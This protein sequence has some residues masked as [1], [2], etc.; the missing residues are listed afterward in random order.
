MIYAFCKKTLS[1]W[2]LMGLTVVPNHYYIPIPDTRYLKNEIWE[3][4]SSLPGIDINE[5]QQLELLSE[6]SQRYKDEYEQIPKYRTDA[7]HQYYINNQSFSSVDGEILYCMIRYF[8]P[9]RI[10]EIGSGNSTLLSAQA[11]LKNQVE[12]HLC[13]LIAIEPYPNEVL[14]KGF[15]GLS[16]MISKKLQDVPIT[17]FTRLEAND[18]LFIDSS[19]VVTIGSD[20]QYEY[21]EILPLLAPG[22]LVH[23]HDI[24]LPMEYRKQWVLQELKFWNEQYLLQAFLIQNAAWKVLWGGSYMH[25]QHPDLLEENFNSYNREERWPGSFWIQRLS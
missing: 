10:I 1:F 22:V 6:F 20:A 17:E 8:K 18:I 14:R 5:K 7:N 15:P 2:H 11:A 25:I 3:R 19:H 12:G 24:F 13:E 16:R 21:L 4:K 23:I 9:K